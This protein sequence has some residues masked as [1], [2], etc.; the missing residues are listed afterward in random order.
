VTDD[1]YLQRLQMI[2]A[3]GEKKKTTKYPIYD[4]IAIQ[5]YHFRKEAGLNQEELATKVG[6]TRTSIVNIEAGRQRLPIHVLANIAEALNKGIIN[7]IPSDKQM[8]TYAPREL[9][10]LDMPNGD[11][12]LKLLKE[13]SSD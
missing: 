13:G 5:I 12:I 11:Q 2:E 8:L 6:L 10:I 4:Y 9:S 7:F 1:K 3:F